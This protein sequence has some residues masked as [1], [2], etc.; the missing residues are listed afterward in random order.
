LPEVE[1]EI[2]SIAQIVSTSKMLNQEFTRSALADRVK[3]SN[4]R[5][6]HLAT[7]GQFSS[8]LEDTF[9]LTWDGRVNVKELSDLLQN[10]ESDPAKAIELLVLSACNTAT[11]DDRAVL[12]LAG[13]TIKSGARSTLATLWPVRDKAAARLMTSFYQQLQQ[14][15][16]SK[17]EALRRAQIELID[18]TDFRDPF[19]WSAFVLVGNWL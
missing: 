16:T 12:G 1:T 10:R 9:L 3:T 15:N 14:P 7:H 19:F 4:A 8:R 2:K 17:A 5:I 13:L 18:K 6:V 11:G